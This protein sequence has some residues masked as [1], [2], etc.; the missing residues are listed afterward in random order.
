MEADVIQGFRVTLEL[1]RRLGLLRKKKD[2]TTVELLK[3]GSSKEGSKQGRKEWRGKK[4][5]HAGRTEGWKEGIYELR[6]GFK[7]GLQEWM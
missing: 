3:A 7:E 2:K 5:R 6:N 4:G 1:L